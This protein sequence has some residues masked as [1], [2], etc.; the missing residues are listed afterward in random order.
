[1]L[2]IALMGAAF[3]VLAGC[4]STSSLEAA[5]A[6]SGTAASSQAAGAAKAPKDAS[7]ATFKADLAATHGAAVA[8]ARESGFEISATS[9]DT[10][11]TGP[12]PRKI[13]VLV[14]SGGE[15]INIML[16]PGAAGMTDVTVWTKRTFVGGAGQKSWNEPV[17]ASMRNK[18]GG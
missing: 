13:G 8:A 15:T 4:A 6:P 11:I 14:G 16:A 7:V 12:R 1:M 17:L 9:S 10:F 18:L 3:A 5:T 2:R